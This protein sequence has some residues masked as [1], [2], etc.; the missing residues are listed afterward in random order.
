MAASRTENG[1]LYADRMSSRVEIDLPPAGGGLPL[2]ELE[3]FVEQARHAGAV[4]DTLVIAV[5]ADQD[6]DMT[7]ALCVEFDGVP[8]ERDGVDE[9]LHLLS[10]IERNDGDVHAQRRAIRELRQRLTGDVQQAVVDE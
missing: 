6:P 4:A 9:L 3:R 7:I 10:E 5:P 2:S 8:G 1:P